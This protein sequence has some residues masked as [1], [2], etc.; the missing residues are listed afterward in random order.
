MG[1]QQARIVRRSLGGTSVDSLLAELEGL[2]TPE[3]RD[4]AIRIGAASEPCL[5]VSK[6]D[7]RRIAKRVG[8]DQG[9]AGDLWAR[10]LHETRILAVLIAEP[11]RIATEEL[12]RWV[13]DADS[14]EIC[15][16]LC[17]DLVCRT[18]APA[19]FV[20]T[21]AADDRLYVRRAA[22][23]TIAN[24][25]IHQPELAAVQLDPFLQSIRA[26]CRDPRA[27]VM[28]A[29]S[30]ALREIGKSG[31]VTHDAAI[32]LKQSELSVGPARHVAA[33]RA[34]RISRLGPRSGTSPIAENKAPHCEPRAH[35][36]R[37]WSE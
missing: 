14:W 33:E 35:A 19:A 4:R 2:A 32:E 9:L 23:A 22:L 3:R 13:A 28:S 17:K 7:L 30:W 27:H 37:I 21:W 25:A 29:A 26:C 1:F 31:L 20:T 34:P 8:R 36:D 5:G 24:L 12:Q 18:A 11:E 6:G 16:T 15:D 10:R